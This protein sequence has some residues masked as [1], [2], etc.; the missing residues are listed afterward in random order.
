M[1]SVDCRFAGL[2]VALAAMLGALL[3]RQ[4]HATRRARFSQPP[5]A[6]M[7]CSRDRGAGARI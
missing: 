5:D 4:H 7:P 2:I 1:G 6:L 3:P